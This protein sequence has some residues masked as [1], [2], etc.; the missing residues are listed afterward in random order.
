MDYQ[1]IGM[2]SVLALFV[3][4]FIGVLM[5]RSKASSGQIVPEVADVK[6]E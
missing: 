5:S 2:L 6:I 1:G 3:A 4:I